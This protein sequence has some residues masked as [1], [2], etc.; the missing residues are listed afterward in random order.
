MDEVVIIDTN[1]PFGML[2]DGFLSCE[3]FDRPLSIPVT[4]G[5]INAAIPMGWVRTPGHKLIIKQ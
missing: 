2:C 3:L 1:I 4:L 5:Y